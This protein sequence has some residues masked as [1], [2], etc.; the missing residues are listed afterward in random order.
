[1]AKYGTF[2][3]GEA[4][5]G[6]DSVYAWHMM[7]DWDQNGAP[8]DDAAGDVLLDEGIEIVQG[9][10]EVFRTDGKGFDRNWVGKMTFVL[11]NADDR[12][13][14]RNDASDIYPNVRPGGRVILT[15]ETSLNGMYYHA[16]L[17]DGTISQIEPADTRG[18]WRKVKITVVDIL[19]RLEGE[20]IAIENRA[21][22][23]AGHLL[24]RVAGKNHAE[25][26]GNG[27]A[28]GTSWVHQFAPG[29]EDLT[30]L[31]W[32]LAE[33]DG[34]VLFVSVNDALQ[35]R[36]R[37]QILDGAWTVQFGSS[38]KTW[39][40]TRDE[41]GESVE[42]QPWE[43]MKK[44]VAVRV[45]R[46]DPLPEGIIFRVRQVRI[47][48][49][50]TKQLSG[51]VREENGQFAN[52]V[53]PVDFNRIAVVFNS[54]LDGEGS[55]MS[56]L[57][58]IVESRVDGNQMV[59]VVENTDSQAGY[60]WLTVAGVVAEVVEELKEETYAVNGTELDYTNAYIQT[61][62]QGQGRARD[63]GE[64]YSVDHLMP[65]VDVIST[66]LAKQVLPEVED[67]ITLEVQVRAGVWQTMSG[68]IA[69]IERRIGV[70]MQVLSRLWVLPWTAKDPAG[71]WQ[72]GKG[73]FGDGS[74]KF[75]R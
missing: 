50:E 42:R 61:A 24:Y 16:V 28:M 56:A 75:G 10:E 44:R 8:E 66:D 25:V 23:H 62:W 13:T 51:A 45:Q 31:L 18:Y 49:G 40:L 71:Y 15:M 3:Y 1:M 38:P 36:S 73:R 43:V 11:N 54:A 27:F 33:M 67:K 4:V 32:D 30:S 41:I 68:R 34:G 53:M 74:M 48:A 55:D 59:I 58:S 60:L 9:R 35:Y 20:T 64:V 12:Y 29:T 47:E 70:G 14:P 39:A 6:M 22:T 19:T 63:W 2:K 17:F 57:L 69:K 52:P 65:M 72:I 46:R 26:N 5:Y 21:M 37:Y 7:M